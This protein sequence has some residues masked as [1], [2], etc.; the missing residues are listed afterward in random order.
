MQVA[1]ERAERQFK[2]HITFITEVEGR[3]N[4]QLK[5]QETIVGKM[6]GSPETGY[7]LTF[8]HANLTGECA[9]QPWARRPSLTS[10]SVKAA[11]APAIA[12]RGGDHIDDGDMI[13]LIDGGKLGL[14]HH[15]LSAV[16]NPDSG[17]TLPNIKKAIYITKTEEA[18]ASNKE[19]T[20]G[21]ATVQQVEMLYMLT[22]KAQRTEKKARVQSAF[23]TTAGAVIGPV[24]AADSQ[25][26]WIMTFADKKSC[27]APRKGR[28]QA[29]QPTTLKSM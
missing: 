22:Q 18:A 24:G 3:E 11:L 2:E 27:M 29:A 28:C 5:I 1:E 8:Y 7:I 19:L 14:E 13:V 16:C 20:R 26:D 9:S 25:G 12:S 15:L 6:R 21:T 10:G 23:G 17:N 4:M